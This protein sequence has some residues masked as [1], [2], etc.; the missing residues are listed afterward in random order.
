MKF[1]MLILVGLLALSCQDIEKVER[2]EN[3]IPESKM[4]EVLTDL[5]LMISARNFNLA[6]AGRNRF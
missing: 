4:V 3:L 6:N 1:R 2:P 5:S